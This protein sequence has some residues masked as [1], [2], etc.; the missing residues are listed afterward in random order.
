MHCVEKF[1]ESEDNFVSRKCYEQSPLPLFTASPRA[2]HH[3]R[4]PA[5]LAAPAGVHERACLRPEPRQHLGRRF[6]CT[7][8]C[9][10]VA[11]Q[12][13]SARPGQRAHEAPMHRCLTQHQRVARVARYLHRAGH[14]VHKAA[15]REGGGWRA[16][17]RLLLFAPPEQLRVA[18][19][20][21]HKR[22]AKIRFMAAPV[23]NDIDC[24][25]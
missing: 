17:H 1:K 14:S 4:C 22:M 23:R 21:V 13:K 2:L 11:Q 8:F 24:C 20:G 6:V 16:L 19:L 12:H 9:Q 7:V 3:H 15:L 18:R 5:R 10:P 25:E